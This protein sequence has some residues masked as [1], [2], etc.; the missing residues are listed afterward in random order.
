MEIFGV[1]GGELLAILIIMLVVAGPKRMIQWAYILGKYTAK[2][3]RVWADTMTYVQKEFEQA[4]LNVE[5]PKEPPTRANLTRMV[6]KQVGKAM[7]PVTKP[8]QDVL[9]EA[10]AEIKQFESQTSIV[11]TPD[12]NGASPNT[13]LDLGSWSSGSDN[14]VS[15]N[16]KTT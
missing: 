1:G 9:N 3:R 12:T 14:R 4:G 7:A 2:A 8:I 15:D 13:R 11:D 16:G 5:L 6:S 10:S